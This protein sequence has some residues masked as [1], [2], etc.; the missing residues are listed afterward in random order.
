MG[1]NTCLISFGDYFQLLLVG[2]KGIHKLKP[3]ND[4]SGSDNIG[5]LAFEKYLHRN[6]DSGA[7]SLVVQMDEVMIQQNL[8]FLSVLDAMRNGKIQDRHIDFMLTRL[9]CVMSVKNLKS[10]HNALHTMPT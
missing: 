10:F 4:T 6:E 3:A 7:K 8:V 9:L 5:R 2:M 1:C